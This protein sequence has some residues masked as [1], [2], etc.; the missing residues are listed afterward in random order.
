MINLLKQKGGSHFCC[1][2]PSQEQVKQIRAVEDWKSISAGHLGLTE[3]SEKLLS[4]MQLGFSKCSVRWGPSTLPFAGLPMVLGAVEATFIVFLVD[5][6]EVVTE[7]TAV[8]KLMEIIEASESN[9]CTQA[10]WAHVRAG[11]L[12]YIPFGKLAIVTTFD[13]VAVATQVATRRINLPNHSCEDQEAHMEEL[14]EKRRPSLLS[15]CRL[16]PFLACFSVA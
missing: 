8:V 11:Q 9:P 12:L 14:L 3:G 5:S 13:E 4:P 6:T 7:A 1:I 10:E 16:Y 2:T 15:P